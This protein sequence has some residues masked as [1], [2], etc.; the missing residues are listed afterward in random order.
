MIQEVGRPHA[1]PAQRPS[2]QTAKRPTMEGWP[3]RPQGRAA[4]L[5]SQPRADRSTMPAT[6]IGTPPPL[7]TPPGKRCPATGYQSK[8][9]FYYGSTDSRP[10][11]SSWA[12]ASPLRVAPARWPL[13]SH[14]QPFDSLS[15]DRPLLDA[16]P[17]ERNP[18]ELTAGAQRAGSIA[19]HCTIL[20]TPPS[21]RRPANCT[22]LRLATAEFRNHAVTSPCGS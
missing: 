1:S 10:N 7:P 8:G 20:H 4:A 11:Q 9:G 19:H 2:G 17:P 3:P 18:A 21:C 16:R 13:L 6:S 14:R 22:G 12:V 15:L 5:P